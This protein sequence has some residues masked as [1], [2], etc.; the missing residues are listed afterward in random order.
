MYAVIATGGKQYRVEENQILRVEKLDGE[1]GASINFDKILMVGNSSEPKIGR[2]YLSGAV[3][4][5][6]ITEQDRAKKI[7]VFKKKRRKGYK[8][9]RGHR[10]CYTAVKIMKI[11]N[12]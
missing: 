3:V 10:Q 4:E 6:E 9:I 8:K 5:A 2:P 1:V 12:G 11:V 7:L